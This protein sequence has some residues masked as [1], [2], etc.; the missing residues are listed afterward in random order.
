MLTRSSVYSTGPRIILGGMTEL[1]CWGNEPENP[2]RGFVD[3]AKFRYIRHWI[4]PWVVLGVVLGRISRPTRP[5]NWGSLTGSHW[6]VSLILLSA[7]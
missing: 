6:R 7:G 5:E 2:A 1:I 3:S 4:R